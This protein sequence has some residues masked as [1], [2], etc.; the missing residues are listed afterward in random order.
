MKASKDSFAQIFP[1]YY[2]LFVFVFLFLYLAVSGSNVG[3]MA[4]NADTTYAAE[5]AGLLRDREC[6][7]PLCGKSWWCRFWHPRRG[8]GNGCLYPTP[9]P[10]LSP[11][12]TDIPSS[13]PSPTSSVC[14]RR[15]LCLD[16]EPACEVAEPLGGWCSLPPA[17]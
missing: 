3:S 10:S 8:R 16:A 2:M 6:V 11:P 7:P 14:T 12:V 4:Q 15:P 17:R 1:L 5:E 9:V 13:S